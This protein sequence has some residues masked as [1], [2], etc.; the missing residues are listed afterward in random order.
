[1]GC[2]ALAQ[3]FGG[4]C[5]INAIPHLISGLTG[6]LFP[7]PFSSPI[8][9]GPSSP[10]VNVLWGYA[11]LA[12]AYYFLVKL[13]SFSFSNP[14]HL[15]PATTGSLLTGIMLAHWFGSANM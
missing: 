12:L 8:G 2:S 13:T 11:N 4:A 6:K 5:L 3:A 10:V 7:S 1:M 9:V 15:I 14:K